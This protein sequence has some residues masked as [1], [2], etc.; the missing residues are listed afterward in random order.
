VEL[1]L[2]DLAQP[3]LTAEQKARGALEHYRRAHQTKPD[4]PLACNNLAWAYL[5]APEPL[6]DG[7]A[8]LPLAEKAVGL[9]PQSPVYRNTLGLA[10]YRAG[11]YR[12]AVEILRANLQSQEDWC[13]AYDLYVL[14]LSCHRLGEVERARD[15]LA[16]AVRWLQTRKELSP[17]HLDELRAFRAEA[18]AVLGI[19]GTPANTDEEVPH[20]RK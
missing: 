2:G 9:A 14:A 10:Y 8:A 3:A 17:E 5:T 20:Q 7:K 18:E 4:D 12:K 11:R 6:R 1:V 19:K 16:W 13:L 15:Y